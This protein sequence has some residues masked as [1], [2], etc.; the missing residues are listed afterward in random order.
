MSIYVYTLKSI[1]IK[2]YEYTHKHFGGYVVSVSD[3]MTGGD[4]A[5]QWEY[6]YNSVAKNICQGSLRLP[7]HTA[8]DPSTRKQ[9]HERNQ[10]TRN[11]NQ[12]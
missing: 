7:D 3:Q 8:D 4:S 9:P 2:I 6:K 11:P 1:H 5:M 10:P 12:V